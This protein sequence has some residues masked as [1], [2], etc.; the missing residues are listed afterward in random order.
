MHLTTYLNLTSNAQSKTLMDLSHHFSATLYG[1]ES[2]D[3]YYELS[4]SR[5]CLVR[6]GPSLMWCSPFDRRRTKSPQSSQSPCFV[7]MLKTIQSSLSAAFH[8]KPSIGTLTYVNEDESTLWPSVRT[9]RNGNDPKRRSLRLARFLRWKL[10]RK[11]R[12]RVHQRRP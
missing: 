2:G 4:S 8:S 7:R 9:D 6:G 10:G 12:N 3:H 5:M 1:L 11:A